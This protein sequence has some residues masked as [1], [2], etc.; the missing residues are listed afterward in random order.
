MAWT[1]GKLVDKAYGSF[2]LSKFNYSITPDQMEE[3]LDF[4]EAM[5]SA[6][7]ANKEIRIGYNHN[8]DAP[9]PSQDS[10]LPDNAYQA[11]L[12]NLALFCANGMGASADVVAA[13]NALDELISYT[14]ARYIPEMKRRSDMPRGAGNKPYRTGA[15][16]YYRPQADIDTGAGGVLEDGMGQPLTVGANGGPLDIKQS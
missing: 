11:V 12:L 16:Q 5:M 4:L 3:A 10:G 14:Q 9:D 8:S 6:W 7:E 1:K 2:G 13:Q 15:G